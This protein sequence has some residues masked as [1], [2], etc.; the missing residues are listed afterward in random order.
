ME[1]FYFL[2]SVMTGCVRWFK[3]GAE[4]HVRTSM[5]VWSRSKTPGWLFNEWIH[6]IGPWLTERCPTD[7]LSLSMYVLQIFVICFKFVFSSVS[8]P[9]TLRLWSME[10]IA[11]ISMVIIVVYCIVFWWCCI[12]RDMCLTITV[13][14]LSLMLMIINGVLKDLQG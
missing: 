3:T 1:L 10:Y 12:S 8:V 2:L 11:S 6:Y 7:W 4:W 5:D 14:R 9:Y 13:I